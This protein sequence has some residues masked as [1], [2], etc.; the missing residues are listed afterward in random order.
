MARYA[1]EDGGFFSAHRDD[2]TPA[3]AHRKFAVPL[4]LNAEDYDG[5]DLRFPEF[6]PRTY[7][8]P[9]GGARVVCCSLLHEA[10][11]VTKGERFVF[12]P[13]LYDEEGARIRQRNLGKVAPDLLRGNRQQRR[14]KRDR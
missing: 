8:P 5:G 12:V 3:T 14:A 2:V 7:R 11:P 10:T 4:N 9:T 6:G 1:A 13:F